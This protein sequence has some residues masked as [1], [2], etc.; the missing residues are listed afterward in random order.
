MPAPDPADLALLGLPPR[1]TLGDVHRAWERIRNTWNTDSLATY[2]LLEDAERAE[3]LARLTAAHHR[4]LAAFGG[5]PPESAPGPWEPAEDL[6]IVLE[7]DREHEP[8]PYLRHHRTTRGLEIQAIERTTRIRAVLLQALEEGDLAT[9][10]E[11]VF[12]RGFVIAYAQ[13]LEL[14]EPEELARSYLRWV[15]NRGSGT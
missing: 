1:A 5:S 15:E 6:P 4:V 10:P 14:P 9:L 8:G 7:P 2:G 3:I 13:A 12:I 11:P